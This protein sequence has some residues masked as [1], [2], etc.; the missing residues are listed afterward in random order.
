MER[1][2]GWLLHCLVFD[3]ILAIFQFIYVGLEEDE[4]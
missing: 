2:S 4:V 1:K 3:A